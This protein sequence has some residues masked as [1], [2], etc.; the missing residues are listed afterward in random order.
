MRGLYCDSSS[1]RIEPDTREF[2]RLIP[3][4][5]RSPCLHLLTPYGRIKNTVHPAAERTSGRLLFREKELQAMT[6]E[7]HY[8]REAIKQAKKAAALKEVPIGCVIVYEDKIIARGYNRRNT[9]KNT[10]SHAELNA[11]R[12]ASKKLGDWRLEGCTLY[13][14][15]EPCQMCAGAIVQARVS[16][17]VI[18][19]MNPK[20]GCAGSILN[21][22][23]MAQFN[24]Q[25]KVTRNVLQEECSEML[26]DFFRQLR[27]W[28]KEEK[29][30]KKALL[31]E[32]TEA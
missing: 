22:L 2:M 6:R 21:L 31:S 3:A 14:T 30:R 15:L 10:L 23:E 8:M 16:E 25:V 32:H 7:E 26:K 28:K 27:V 20:A 4:E 12:K 5:L 18:G 9:D 11:I 24:H 29:E 13:V 17:V 19:C 1:G